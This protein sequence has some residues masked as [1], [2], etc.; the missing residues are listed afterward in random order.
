MKTIAI[1]WCCLVAAFA[2]TQQTALSQTITGAWK[3][4]T[5]NVRTELKLVKKGDSLLGTV[6]YY[7]SKA[8]YRRYGVRGYFDG[9]TN[10]VVW[11]DESLVEEKGGGSLFGS[12]KNR[13]LR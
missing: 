7:T 12:S 9:Q 13:Y 3:G 8:N 11:W 5:G 10:A 2:L 4:K 1:S 6:Y